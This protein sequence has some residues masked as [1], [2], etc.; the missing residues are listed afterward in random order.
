MLMKKTRRGGDAW[1]CPVVYDNSPDKRC[2]LDVNHAGQHRAEW[3]AVILFNTPQ[4]ESRDSDDD[5]PPYT[6]G[7]YSAD[8]YHGIE[9]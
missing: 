9:G 4:S 2:I 3:R 8:L 7:D 1:R 5:L 6:Q